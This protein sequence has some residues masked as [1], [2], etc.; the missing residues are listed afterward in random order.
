MSMNALF[1]TYI[2]DTIVEKH[3]Q[4]RYGKRYKFKVEMSYQYQYKS[5]KVD[6]HFTADKKALWIFKYKGEYYMNIVED[7]ELKDKYTVIDLYLSLVDNAQASYNH[8]TGLAKYKRD[9]A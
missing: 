2:A 5:C 1:K 8:L 9:H 7:V 6:I 3:L 4:E